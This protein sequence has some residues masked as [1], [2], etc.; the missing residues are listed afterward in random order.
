MWKAAQRQLAGKSAIRW[1]DF[2]GSHIFTQVLRP[3]FQILSLAA[4]RAENYTFPP[5]KTTVAKSFQL[6]VLRGAFFGG[7]FARSST[8]CEHKFSKGAKAE[9]FSFQL[10]FVPKNR[11]RFL[12]IELTVSLAKAF[13]GASSRPIPQPRVL[14]G[15]K[16]TRL[17][18]SRSE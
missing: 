4:K 14:G 15:S 1:C 12:L 5:V 16:N 8:R 11:N 17:R 7:F 2:P 13:D 9:N 3:R 18:A 10:A 6:A